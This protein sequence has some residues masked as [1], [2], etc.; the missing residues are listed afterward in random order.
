M[1]FEQRGALLRA[2]QKVLQ[3]PEKY[4]VGNAAEL[5]VLK[6]AGIMETPS[7]IVTTHDDDTNIYLTIY[8]RRLRPD[9][10]IISRATRERNIATLQRAGADFIM[11]YASMGS[12]AMLNLWIMLMVAEGLDVLCQPHWSAKA[13]WK[14]RSARK[15]V[16]W[17]SRW[18]FMTALA[19]VPRTGIDHDRHD[20]RRKRIYKN[21][22][23]VPNIE[24]T[25]HCGSDTTSQYLT[26]RITRLYSVRAISYF[27]FGLYLWQH[28]RSYSHLSDAGILPWRKM[29]RPKPNATCH[30]PHPCLGGFYSGA[31]AF[32]S[33]TRSQVRRRGV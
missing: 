28:H 32:R 9:V 16:V 27:L 23:W 26:S 5:E 1:G 20:H 14:H 6:R 29:G 24:P 8:C 17:L 25:F 18:N 4:V 12:N 13:C 3:N 15:Q 7:V 33:R 21:R 31:G 11:S 19:S 22:M 30:V 2:F 10:Q